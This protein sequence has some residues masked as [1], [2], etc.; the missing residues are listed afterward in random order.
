[1]NLA[2]DFADLIL[3]WF[4]LLSIAGSHGWM[5][6]LLVFVGCFEFFF[7]ELLLLV[8]FLVSVF[9]LTPDFADLILGSLMIL[10]V[11]V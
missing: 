6:M 2:T 10:S 8:W 1:L 7:G 3:C 4:T 9:P 11:V 5:V